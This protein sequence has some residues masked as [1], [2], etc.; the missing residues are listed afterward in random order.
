MPITKVNWHGWRNWTS[1]VGHLLQPPFLHPFGVLTKDQYDDLK[2]YLHQRM[3]TT[4][5]AVENLNSIIPKVVSVT[6][7]RGKIVVSEDFWNA[8]RDRMQNDESILTLDGKARISDKHWK[9]VEQ[10][11]K[12]SNLLGKPMS[13]EEVERIIDQTAPSSWEQWLQKNKQKVASL[14]GTKGGTSKG[15]SGETVISREEFIKHV[16]VELAKSR[17]EID[18]EMASLRKHLNTM[19]TEVRDTLSKFD[20]LPRSQITRLVERLVSKEIGDRQL[21][22]GSKAQI[23][24]ALRRRINYFSLGNNAQI[25]VTLTSPTWEPVMPRL[26]SKEF[27]KSRPPQFLPHAFHALTPWSEPG[28]C[29]CAATG[30]K[31][32][33]PPTLSVNLVGL[34]RPQ[35]FVLE[36]MDPSATTDPLAMPKHIEIWARFDEP[37]VHAQHHRRMMDDYPAAAADDTNQYLFNARFVK[38]DEFAYEHRHLDQGVFV[39]KLRD[40]PGDLDVATSGVVIRA[41]TNYGAEDHTCFYRVR[42]YGEPAEKVEEEGEKRKGWW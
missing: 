36:H 2:D 42:M 19:V 9:A 15:D 31:T 4:E 37:S 16:S 29:W 32:K 23:D 34:V 8:L 11:L 41:V 21:R 10:R 14:I 28:Q 33:A 30:G 12:D 13:L 26:G 6:K 18:G 5:A 27:L 17:K 7:W 3:T 22:G 39:H 40:V 35:Y 38:L 24:A 20:T 25:D 1:N